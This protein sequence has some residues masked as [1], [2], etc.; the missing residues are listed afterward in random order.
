MRAIELAHKM[1]PIAEASSIPPD[2]DI[3]IRCGDVYFDVREAI[4]VAQPVVVA[5]TTPSTEPRLR[6]IV[7][8][9]TCA[10][11]NN[12]VRIAGL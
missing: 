3:V 11:P 1:F 5:T 6:S 8:L 4:L 2:A 7:V 12:D 10:I 9:K